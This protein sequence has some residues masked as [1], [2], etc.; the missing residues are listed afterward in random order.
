MTDNPD[1]DF[2][3]DSH[4]EPEKEAPR[5]T[6]ESDNQAESSSAGATESGEAE[7]NPES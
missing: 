7:D 3:D 4:G 5:E 1:D 6:T 2:L